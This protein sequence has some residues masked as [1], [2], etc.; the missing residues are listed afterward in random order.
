MVINLG[1]CEYQAVRLKF[2]HYGTSWMSNH[3]IQMQEQ[4]FKFVK[5]SGPTMNHL[6][7]RSLI[8]IRGATKKW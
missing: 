3:V 7:W 5:V 1:E 2:N 4:K 6:R 8:I